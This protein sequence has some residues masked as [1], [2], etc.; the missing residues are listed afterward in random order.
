MSFEYVTFKTI[1]GNRYVIPLSQIV[2]IRSIHTTNMRSTIV[3][4]TTSDRSLDVLEAS[5]D[6]CDEIMKNYM[7]W[8]DSLNDEIHVSSFDFR[9]SLTIIKAHIAELEDDQEK[10]TNT[11]SNT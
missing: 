10:I 5:R 7:N 2:S 6:I 3:I 4:N 11:H 9:E 1:V 8:M